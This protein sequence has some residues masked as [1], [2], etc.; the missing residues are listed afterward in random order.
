[1]GQGLASDLDQ[2]WELD[3]SMVVVNLVSVPTVIDLLRLRQFL[4]LNPCQLRY[5]L[6]PAAGPKTQFAWPVLVR[7]ATVVVSFTPQAFDRHFLVVSVF[8]R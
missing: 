1:M 6:Y 3:S 5:Y 4:Q 2:Q 8:Q 7:P